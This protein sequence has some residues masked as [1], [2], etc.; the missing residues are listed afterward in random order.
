M[1]KISNIKVY[2]LVES[3]I[4]SGNAMRIDPIEDL[5]QFDES[6]EEFQKGIKRMIRA[7]KETIISKAL[8]TKE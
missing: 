2:D 3:V 1:L 8:F 6:S 7:T 4:A 5:S